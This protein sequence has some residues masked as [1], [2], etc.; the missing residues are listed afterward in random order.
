[1]GAVGF[2]GV[3]ALVAGRLRRF[4]FLGNW[5]AGGLFFWGEGVIVVVG[6]PWTGAAGLLL[7]FG[8]RRLVEDE[9]LYAHVGVHFFGGDGVG[10]F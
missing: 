7:L 10:E 2:L 1:M 5:P 4:T 8:G 3:K 9:Y 6:A